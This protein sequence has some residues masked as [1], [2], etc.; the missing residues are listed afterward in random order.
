MNRTVA[1]ALSTLAAVTCEDLLIGALNVQ[2]EPKK[3]A[4]YAKWMSFGYGILSFGLVFVVEQLG[5]ILQATLTLN[6]MIGGITLGLF[7]L[8]IFYKRANS[9]GTLIG[10]SIA[11]CV[12]IFIGV[13]AQVKGTE[14]PALTSSIESCNCY[15][16]AT[17]DAI[18]KEML[19]DN[20]DVSPL[21]RLSYMW[22]SFISTV[23]TVILGMLFSWLVDCIEFYRENK[24]MAQKTDDLVI[25]GEKVESYLKSSKES[26]NLC[27]ILCDKNDEKS[28]PKLGNDNLAFEKY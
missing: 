6:G 15:Y 10:G 26:N 18:E 25:N 12:V 11:F 16:N 14:T 7:S 24:A 4:H 28:F 20:E 1:S 19:N 21:F 27:I 9:T 17:R 3:M 8:G 2:I 5:G 22:Y 13:M 23:L